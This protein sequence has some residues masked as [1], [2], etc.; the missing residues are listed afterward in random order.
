MTLAEA[1]TDELI[2]LLNAADG[3][4][5]QSFAQLLQSAARALVGQRV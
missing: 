5:Q 2:A 3:I 1:A 4:G